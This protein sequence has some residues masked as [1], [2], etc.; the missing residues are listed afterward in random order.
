MS[1]KLTRRDFMKCAG[2][3]VLAVGAAGI[4]T[5][6]EDG[7]ATGATIT[8]TNKTG[9]LKGIKIT[10][11]EVIK[12]PASIGN[13]EYTTNEYVYPRLKI[14]NASGKFFEGFVRTNFETTVDGKQLDI[15]AASGGAYI[16]ALAKGYN[17]I[18]LNGVALQNGDVRNGVLCYTLPKGW[19]TLQLKVYANANATGD[20]ITFVLNNP[21]K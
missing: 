3:T 17:V 16:K 20:N 5:G 19:K 7:G 12:E 9:T 14:E 13:L 15:E 18:D 21:G 8:G 4:L 1:I 10:V 11:T 6:C 2:I